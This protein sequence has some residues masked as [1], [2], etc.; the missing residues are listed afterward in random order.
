MTR[1]SR[2]VHFH[3]DEHALSL[4]ARLAAT[5]GAR[6]EDFCRHQGL[7][8]R[9][10]TEGRR[11]ALQELAYI[12]GIDATRLEA[13]AT[14]RTGGYFTIGPERLL[15][16]NLVR[17]Y[18][19]YCPFC[20]AE[21]RRNG[22][23]SFEARPFGR[24]SWLVN[25]IASCPLHD[26]ALISIGKGRAK[27]LAPGFSISLFDA[28]VETS[29]PF[30]QTATEFEAY[31]TARLLGGRPPASDFLGM[32]PLHVVGSVCELVGAVTM[33]GTKFDRRGHGDAE[34]TAARQAGY[35]LLSAAGKPFEEFLR[36]L[37]IATR[38]RTG[39]LL[40]TNVYGT[41]YSWLRR[42]SKE[43]DYDCL[44]DAI[45]RVSVEELP[46]GHD[47][48]VFGPLGERKFHSVKTAS[49]EFSIGETTLSKLLRNAG[50][51]PP[52]EAGVSPS[53]ILIPEAEMSA[54]ARSVGAGFD[55]LRA[56]QRLK[57]LESHFDTLEKLGIFAPFVY[58]QKSRS[59]TALYDP[60]ELDAAIA[61]L[62]GSPAAADFRA[63]DYADISRIRELA[64][65]TFLEVADLLHS[66]MLRGT[67]LD[68]SETGIDILRLNVAEVRKVMAGRRPITVRAADY[69]MFGRL[70]PSTVR[71]LVER[72]Y[73]SVVEVDDADG[74]RRTDLAAWSIE[75]F[76]ERYHS[77]YD[78]AQR[79]CSDRRSI[80]RE[81]EAAGIEPVINHSDPQKALYDVSEVARSAVGKGLL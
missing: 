2:S 28:E 6:T 78:L 63:D 26:V 16:E 22:L 18:H 56:C 25:F 72:G 48:D 80:R 62:A 34:W 47:D 53:M 49:K 12:A 38:R 14:V 81:L 54:F 11:A 29:K 76:E 39:E 31:M 41:L 46:L 68:A 71:K 37:A 77:L 23:G 64:G 24:L 52:F 4:V 33:F 20:L 59:D 10:I 21:D 60:D 74:L 7:A 70:S 65:C 75:L 43:P 9:D 8:L 79:L 42:R 27:R 40:P 51:I 15:P 67:V 57:L 19:R 50:V 45:R 35:R 17:T 61:G 44:R 66:G 5:N 36:E 1:L 58:R 32:L 30:P 3:D 69:D 13:R 55:R 73:L